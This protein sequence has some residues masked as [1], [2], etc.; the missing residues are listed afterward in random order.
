MPVVTI[1]PNDVLL[2]EL[3]SDLQE[4]RARGGEVCVFADTDTRINRE[5]AACM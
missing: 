1:A 2:E 5:P 3:K 4:V